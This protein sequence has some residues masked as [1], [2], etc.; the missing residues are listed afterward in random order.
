MD[1]EAAPLVTP[2]VTVTPASS[3]VTST[4]PL[5]VTIAVSGGSGNPVATGSIVLSTG[6]YSSTAA[7]ISQGSVILTVPAGTLG[8]GSNTLSAVYTPDKAS[9]LTYNSATGTASVTAPATGQ[10]ITFAAARLAGNLR[11]GSHDLA[12][13][14]RQSIGQSSDLF[15]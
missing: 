10:T 1:V 12:L 8:G 15:D 5:R 9:A 2:G 11:L 6:S 14:H 3:S 7:P 13:G 4:Q